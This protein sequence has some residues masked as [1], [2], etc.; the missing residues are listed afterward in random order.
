Y[1]NVS[2]IPETEYY[3]NGVNGYNELFISMKNDISFRGIPCR[4]SKFSEKHGGAIGPYL[5]LHPDGSL[6]EAE[7]SR[8]IIINGIPAAE[9]GD[10][11]LNKSGKLRYTLLSKNF[12]IQGIPCAGQ[13]P[14][15][16]YDG[17]ELSGCDLS[18]VFT[19]NEIVF[20]PDSSAS[21]YSDGSIWEVTL[22]KAYTLNQIQFKK[23]DRLTFHENGSLKEARVY[24]P[25][26]KKGITVEN[27]F[28]AGNHIF[29]FAKNGKLIS[30]ER[31][32]SGGS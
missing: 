32:Y 7:L 17:G 25:D 28:Y 11:F 2:D 22:E 13:K 15:Y 18:E 30:A 6:K 31:F 14:V 27:Q 1:T 20:K 5:I 24:F 3:R 26:D 8:D 12:I 19:K 29:T 16:F 21:F 23:W 4:K 9:G 10:I